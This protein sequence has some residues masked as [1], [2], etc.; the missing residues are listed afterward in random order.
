MLFIL[1]SFRYF[2]NSK[3]ASLQLLQ[4]RSMLGGKSVLESRG[5]QRGLRVATAKF[6]RE[7]YV[8]Y[9]LEEVSLDK[10]NNTHVAGITNIFISP[11]QPVLL[12]LSDRGLSNLQFQVHSIVSYPVIRVSCAWSQPN[13]I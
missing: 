5:N 1:P 6:N 3:V 9:Y 2:H 12:T 11:A 8:T 7:S 13:T 10:S 4:S